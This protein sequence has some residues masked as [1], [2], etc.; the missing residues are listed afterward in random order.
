MGCGVFYPLVRRRPALLSARVGYEGPEV[1]VA[2]KS[3]FRR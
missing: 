1:N 3:G 2:E